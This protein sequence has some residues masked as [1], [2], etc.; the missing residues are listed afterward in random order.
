MLSTVGNCLPTVFYFINQKK[1]PVKNTSAE[2]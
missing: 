1:T 2:K